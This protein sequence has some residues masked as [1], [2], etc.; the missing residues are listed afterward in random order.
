MKKQL[1]Q[2]SGT[3]Q[4]QQ[5]QTTVTQPVAQTTTVVTY[6]SENAKYYALGVEAYN[7]KQYALAAKNFLK[8]YELKK[9]NNTLDNVAMSYYAGMDYKNGKKYFEQLLAAGVSNGGKTEFYIGACIMMM[10]DRET[11]C[12]YYNISADKGF[13]MGKQIIVNT[14]PK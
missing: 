8:S 1:E 6:A 12:Q 14:C 11:A 7:K 9:D 3:T 4:V 13:E 10:G 2:S 5:Q